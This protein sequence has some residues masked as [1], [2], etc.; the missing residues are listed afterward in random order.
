MKFRSYIVDAVEYVVPHQFLFGTHMVY[1][2]ISLV[3]F[4]LSCFAEDFPEK[5]HGETVY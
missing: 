1:F 2:P 5:H 4:I 3:Q